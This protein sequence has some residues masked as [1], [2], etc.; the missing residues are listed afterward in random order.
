MKRI[1]TFFS[2][3][4]LFTTLNAQEFAAIY[5]GEKIADG[6]TLIVN[7]F[8]RSSEDQYGIW[9]SKPPIVLTASEEVNVGL[10]TTYTDSHIQFCPEAEGELGGCIPAQEEN[11][12]LVAQKSFDM[13]P[14]KSV[15]LAI[16]WA[17]DMKNMGST[18]KPN[19]LSEVSFSVIYRLHT[20]YSF[21]LVFNSN[22]TA[23][24]D[25]VAGDG[26]FVNLAAGN[27]LEYNVPEGT[28]LD[29]YSINGATVLERTVN[30]HGSLSLDRLAPGVYLYK[31]G[32]LSGKVLVK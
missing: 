9:Q 1:I 24:I 12:L 8:E 13:G 2:A 19:V 21:T 18:T 7:G 25:N 27:I 29:V 4:A 10:K 14:D 30:G 16:H 11:G 5:N 22:Y 28:K 3:V 32:A 31:A 17:D 20:V 15:N 26:N 23:G 6:A